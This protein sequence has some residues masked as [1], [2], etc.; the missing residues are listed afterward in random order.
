M[1]RFTNRPNHRQLVHLAGDIANT[2]GSS[3]Q[4]VTSIRGLVQASPSVYLGIRP[5]QLSL[6]LIYRPTCSGSRCSTGHVLQLRH[7]DG[8]HE[9]RTT[10]SASR[11]SKLFSLNGV[12]SVCPSR[13]SSVQ[14][15]HPLLFPWLPVGG[16]ILYWA[17]L[18]VA[19]SLGRSGSG[20]AER[21]WH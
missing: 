19:S 21:L 9:L 11:R 7:F 13:A 17:N 6:L 8:Y 16:K 10:L 12:S 18:N 5:S 14:G 20:P 1:T 3:P 4:S 2:L 15:D